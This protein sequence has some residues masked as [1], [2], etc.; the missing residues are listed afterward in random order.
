L[1]PVTSLEAPRVVIPSVLEDVIAE[2]LR[3]LL[4]GTI[5]LGINEKLLG[6][7]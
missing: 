3:E 4:V 6:Q 7:G 2:K 5:H 1:D